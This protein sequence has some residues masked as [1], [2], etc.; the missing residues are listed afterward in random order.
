MDLFQLFAR[1]TLDSSQYD[2]GLDQAE[3]KGSSFGKALGGI[4]KTGAAALVAVGTTAVALGGAMV[5]S[6]GATAAYGDNIDKMSQK[7]GISAQAYQE[8]DAILQHSGTSIDSMNRGM[9]TLQKN[10]VDSADK[11]EA[12]GLTQEQVASMS[13]EELFAAT[14]EGLQNMGEGAE[15]TALAS[16]LLGG[17][18]KELGALLNTSAEDTEA[19][20]QRV[21][22]LGGVMSDE[23]VKAAAAY[24][25]ALQDMQTAFSGLSRNLSAKFMPAIT[26][27]MD[28]LTSFLAGDEG[29]LNTMQKGISGFIDNLSE[30]LPKVMDF[31]A[32]IVEA[33]AQGI[34]KNIPALFQSATNIIM[35]F[36][37]FVLRNLPM[38]VQTGAS[39]IVQLAQGIG[40][41]LPTLMP[42]VVMVVTEVAN[43][44]IQNA[45]L[46]LEA[47]LGLLQ[48]FTEGLIA[49]LPILIE[50]LP[51]LVQSAM[52]ALIACTPMLI[53]CVITLV[54]ALVDALPDIIISII[55][56]LPTLIDSVVNGLIA[57]LPQLIAATVQLVAGVV[58]ALPQIF[59][60]VV[61]ALVQLV[62]NLAGKVRDLWTKFKEA[63][64]EWINKIWAGIKEKWSGLIQN[65]V[66]FFKQIP[67]K[68]SSALASIGEVGKNLVKGLWNGITNVT[69]WVL[70]KIKGFG[71]SILN[72]IKSI[73]GIHSPSSE[74]AFFGRMLD[75]GL[76]KGI[77]DNEKKLRAQVEESYDFRDI[78]DDNQFNSELN[79]SGSYSGGVYGGGK[80][81]GNNYSISV[82]VNG[83]DSYN[84]K[85]LADLVAERISFE[86]QKREAALA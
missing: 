60:S 75:E 20:R 4:A 70:D 85:A 8:W 39:L 5:K 22:E 58:K 67:Q 37:D 86:I 63:A 55:E 48:S 23:A 11:F 13:T 61:T 25:D 33:V 46:L 51:V 40:Q 2:E 81:S 3:K 36:A 78:L 77:R 49:A 76:A 66:N 72:G 74:M 9:V 32:G 65:V 16:E 17:S 12:L 26:E 21:H 56:I 6:A 1:L 84:I 31:G 62:V 35:N 18:A 19:M 44:L 24:Q 79:L 38:I 41:T 80:A 71:Q 34:M 83:A 50:Q 54:M 30:E 64:K 73:F 45:P 42:T 82:T 29:G 14:I 47:A 69:G 68:I 7:M 28:G 10:A 43:T 53:E 59:V 27:V 57:C 15:R 52:D